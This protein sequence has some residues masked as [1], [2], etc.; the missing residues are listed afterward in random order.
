[1]RR[2]KCTQGLDCTP[3][4]ATMKQYVSV[5]DPGLSVQKFRGLPSGLRPSQGAKRKQGL[6]PSTRGFLMIS[7]L[8]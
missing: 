4:L 1:M 6:G 7:F 3:S 5:L 2:T 8:I